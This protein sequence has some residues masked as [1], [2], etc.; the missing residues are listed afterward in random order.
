MYL[1]KNPIACKEG[2]TDVGAEEGGWCL[3]L[4]VPCQ[5]VSWDVFLCLPRQVLLAAPRVPVLGLLFSLCMCCPL[6]LK[7]CM[8][9]LPSPTPE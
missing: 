6:D 7:L 9:S 2:R 3:S 1:A 4:M 5:C 8:A